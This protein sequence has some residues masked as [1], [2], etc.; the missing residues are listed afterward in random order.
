[1]MT[2]TDIIGFAYNPAINKSLE[3]VNSLIKDL[4][5]SRSSWI[6]PASNIE[7]DKD[8]LDKTS[9]VITVGGDGT[10]LRVAKSVMKQSIPILGINLGRVGFMTELELDEALLKIP[11]YLSGSY[12]VEE[13]MMLKAV[14]VSSDQRSPEV[15]FHALNDVV[16]TR[17]SLPR[18]LDLDTRIDGVLLT[19][20]RADGLI[21]ST[22][23]GSTGYSLSAGGPILYPEAK[24]I[25]MQPLAAHLSFQTGLVVSDQSNIELKMNGNQLSI[26]SIDGSNDNLEHDQKVILS[27]SPYV[28]RFLRK[29]RSGEF[30]SNLTQKLGVA[31]RQ[32]PNPKII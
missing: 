21:V 25:I 1:M 10:I 29:E 14:I 12:R 22:P 19:T 24:Q 30:Y 26:V 8:I 2:R 7:I 15:E 31:G 16:I 27:K 23:T 18:L 13:R 3:F 6:A 11:K 32:V 20:Y 4:D 9:V 28:A 17:G 5:L